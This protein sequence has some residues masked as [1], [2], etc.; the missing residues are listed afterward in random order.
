M[1][2]TLTTRWL[3][4]DLAYF[5]S[6]TSTNQIASEMA[7]RGAPHG[8]VVLADAQT[9]GRGRY[10]RKW[11]S[12]NGKGL[13]FSV[14]LRPQID[15]RV[16]HQIPMLAAISVASALRGELCLPAEIKW[17]NDIML[18]GRKICGILAETRNGTGSIEFI[19]LG[20]G[21]NV[22]Q[23]G[24]DFPPDLKESAGSL[25]MAAGHPFDRISVLQSILTRL[26]TWYDIWQERGFSPIH[27]EWKIM[28]PLL[29]KTVKLIDKK[30][31]IIGEAF[32]V[33]HEGA[34]LIKMGDGSIRRFRYGEVSLRGG[35]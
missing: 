17:P 15:A 29:G 18:Y 3:G 32:D 5:D 31:E 6:V 25:L 4:K 35:P 12:P 28:C 34:L 9:A 8:A 22:N 23:D 20:I 21:V 30:E 19:V 13:W 24:D 14:I 10:G 16:S 11:V 7:S 1:S 33:D 2:I 26:E 27:R